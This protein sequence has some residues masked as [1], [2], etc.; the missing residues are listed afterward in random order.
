[1]CMLAHVDHG[2]SALSDALI[3]ANGIISTRMAG[4]IRYMDSREDEQRRGITMKSSS[5]ALGHRFSGMW[6]GSSLTFCSLSLCSAWTSEVTLF[7]RAIKARSKPYSTAWHQFTVGK[8][9]YR[10]LG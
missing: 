3:S 4:K 2:K 8:C 6:L 9:L 5:I 7:L 1:M 10:V